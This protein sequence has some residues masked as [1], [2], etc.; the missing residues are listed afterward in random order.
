MQRTF[1]LLALALSLAAAQLMDPVIDADDSDLDDEQWV[2]VPGGVWLHRECIYSVPS[3]HVIDKIVRSPRRD[4]SM[5][6]SSAC[7]RCVGA[8]PIRCAPGAARGSD[9]LYCM[10]QTCF[11]PFSSPIPLTPP[12][13]RLQDVHYTPSNELM[14]HM[15]ASFTAPT[16]PAN[17]DGQV[18]YFWPGFKR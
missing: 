2:R 13:L 4:V 3:G 11:Y 12:A 8:V 6:F 5:P 17:D 10:I 9:L 18:V 7:M 1:I 14:T 16:L 15:N